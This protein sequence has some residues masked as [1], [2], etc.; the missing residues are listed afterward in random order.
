MTPISESAA[1]NGFLRIPG[2]EIRIFPEKVL[3]GIE[4]NSLGPFHFEVKERSLMRVPGSRY[5]TCPP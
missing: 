3:L 5:R 4:R 2:A 1:Q